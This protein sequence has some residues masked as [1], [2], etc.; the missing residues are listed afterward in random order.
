M[1]IY[2]STVD[3]DDDKELERGEGR[4]GFVAS[5]ARSFDDF[6]T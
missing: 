2:S 5:K 1:V 3:G 6:E 4:R